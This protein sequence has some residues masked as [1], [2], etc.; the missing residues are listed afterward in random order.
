MSRSLAFL[1]DVHGNLPALEAALRDLDARGVDEIYFLGDAIGKGPSVHEVLSLLRER[2]RG[3]VYGNWDRL[4][5][6]S[7]DGERFGVPYYR[8]RL[9]AEERAWLAS[10]PETLELRFAGRSVLGY[11]GRFSID[12]VVTPMLNNER[13]NVEKAMYRFGPH[14]ITVMG[15]AHHSFLLTNQ[16]RYLLNTGAV[17]NPCDRMPLVSYLLLHER[18]GA[19]SIEH[20]RVP[21][22]VR[23]AVSLALR[24]PDLPM[25]ETYIRETVTAVYSR[26]YAPQTALPRS[27]WED[28]PL[29]VYEDYAAREG[30][31]SA[32]SHVL[33]EQMRDLPAGSVCLLGVG[34][35]SGLAFASAL[36][37]EHILGVDVSESFLS[38]CRARFAHLGPRL[39]LL[40]LDLR[41]PKARLPH[42]EL[43]LADLV[44]E[45]AGLA[46]FVRQVALCAPRLLSCVVN[47]CHTPPGGPFAPAFAD[48]EKQRCDV[49][50]Q[51]LVRALE[52]QGLRMTRLQTY[53]GGGARLLLRLD[54]VRP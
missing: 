14:D 37:Y 51:A 38:A 46:A 45:E 6:S 13:E 16:G 1:S 26:S 47:L 10:L 18:D 30:L 31:S 39:E 35:G 12:R 40:R 23:R 19:F 53:P 21:Y 34:G 4:I 7:K 52:K 28:L 5:L 9:N 44:I 54:F 17:G 42:A 15:D 29:S 43:L 50:P 22:D 11:H 20:V 24:S 2:C 49:D 25:L 3:A 27:P 8:A 48:I 32:L 33:A 41:D 36:S